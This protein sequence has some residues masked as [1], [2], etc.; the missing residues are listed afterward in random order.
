MFRLTIAMATGIFLS[1]SFLPDGRGISLL[2]GVSSVFLFV[3]GVVLFCRK[4]HRRWIFGFMVSLSMVCLGAVLLLFARQRIRFSWPE[5]ER[6]YVG[7]VT[8]IPRKKGKTMEA[9]VDIVWMSR[10][11]T[12][13]WQPVDRRV[14]LRWIPDSLHYGLQCGDRFCCRAVIGRPYNDWN[15]SDFDYGLYL[16]RQGI[17]GTGISFAGNWRRLSG[18]SPVSFRQTALSWREEVLDIFRSWSLDPDVFAVVSA[19][20]VGDKSMLTSE[21]KDSYTAA[22]TSHV[23]ALSGLHIGILTVLVSWLLRPLRYMRGGKWIISLCLFF[24]LWGFAFLSGLSSSVIRAVLMFSIYVI[25]PVFTESRYSGFYAISLAAFLMLLYNPLYLFDISFQLSFTAVLSIMLFYPWIERIWKVKGRIFRYVWQTVS[26][27]L[28]AQL[29]TLPLIL[30]CFGSFPTYFLIANVVVAPLAVCILG[31]TLLAL[32]LSPF[33]WACK[34]VVIPINWITSF[35]NDTMYSIR[36]WEGAQIS[37]IYL[38]A[39]QSAILA[40]I[41]IGWYVYRTRR[42]CRTLLFVLCLFDLLLSTVVYDVMHP[43]GNRMIHF[44]RSGVYLCQN[45]DSRKLE[46]TS[47]SPVKVDT[48]YVVRL[49]DGSWRNHRSDIPFNVHFMYLVRGFRGDIGDLCSLFRLQ[50]VLLAPDLPDWQRSKLQEECDAMGVQYIDLKEKGSYTV[51][52]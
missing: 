11:D 50:I 52:L 48:F 32:C 33:P 8:D 47:F 16:E 24:F 40:A 31:G 4:F 15:I 19:L 17:S 39:W 12:V 37:S 7:W 22:G 51:L 27:S 20:A 43:A 28:A 6:L 13:G 46:F 14:L 45:R 9:E 36:Q 35:L 42:K 49:D 25:A 29:G 44:A 10:I 30:Y 3:S 26:L 2:Q 18:R 41:I 38:T 23:L 1:D 21:L 5:E 34:W